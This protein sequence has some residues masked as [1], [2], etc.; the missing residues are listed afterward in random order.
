M[1]EHRTNKHI[2]LSLIFGARLLVA[3]SVRA[4]VCQEAYMRV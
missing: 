4:M 1:T 3:E 2:D